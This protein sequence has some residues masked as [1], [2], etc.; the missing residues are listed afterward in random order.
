MNGKIPFCRIIALICWCLFCCAAPASTQELRVGDRPG[1][2]TGLSLLAAYAHQFDAT[3]HTGGDFH[4]DRY[5]LRMDGFKRH[6][7]VLSLG[8]GVA[9]DVSDY[10]FSGNAAVPVRTPWDQVHVLTLSATGMYSPDEKWRLFVAPSLGVA[11]GSGADWGDSLVYGGI[12]WTSFRCTPDLVVGL[13]AGLFSK[14]EEFSA[15][16][17]VV[18][19]WK[20]SDRMRLS[21]PLYDGVTGPAGLELSYKFDGGSSVA[22][23]GSYRSQRFRLDDSGGVRG[24]V[25]ED[26][27]FPLWLKLS[28]R[29]GAQGT[30]NFLGGVIAGGKLTLEDS[31]GNTVE[32]Q[33]YDASPFLSSTFSFKF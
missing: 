1:S 31:H 6:S 21:N 12:L 4:V 23:G 9:Y 30:L 7:D 3:L 8:V 14:P 19:D 33:D 26:Q 15:F 2:E 32:E 29:V 16:P 25:G 10:S 24:G 28:T 18:I 27:G 22:A 13:G 11:A 5:F 17:V 20:I